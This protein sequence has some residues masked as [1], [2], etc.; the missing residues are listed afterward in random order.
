V[1]SAVYASVVRRGGRVVVVEMWVID[2]GDWQHCER[3]QHVENE[4]SSLV[5]IQQLLSI[6]LIC[7]GMSRK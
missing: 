1:I 3:H 6:L 4:R 5:A 7:Q 2:S